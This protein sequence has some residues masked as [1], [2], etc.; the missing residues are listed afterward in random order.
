MTKF[1]QCSRG[2]RQGCPL[3]P[4]LFNTYLNDLIPQLEASN[5]SPLGL[6]NKTNV[7]C[8]MYA[9]DLILLSKSPQGLQS[10]LNKLHQ[11]CEVWHLSINTEKT[12]C[13]TLQK[14][15]K[16]NN[17]DV[18]L[19]NET[20]I[21]NVSEYTYLGITFIPSGSF[22]LTFQNLSNKANRSFF[23]INNKHPIKKL[24]IRTSLKLFDSMISP[25][26]LYCS[27][28]W[29]AFDYVDFDKWDKCEIERSHMDFCKRI[30]GLNRSTSNILTRGEMGRYPLKIAADNRFISFLRHIE[31]MPSDSLVN[32]S[33]LI[34][35]EL[36]E[37]LNCL[38]HLKNIEYS[39]SA[40]SIL[41]C[42]KS[43]TKLALRQ[44][45]TTYWKIKLHQNPKGNFLAELNKD[46][47]YETYLD[48]PVHRKLKVLTSKLR[49]SDHDL[50]IENGRRMR[51]LIPREN[52]ICHLCESN[53]LETELHFLATCSRYSTL[54]KQFMSNIFKQIP[55]VRN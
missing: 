34:N 23:S 44:A 13:M 5:S 39:T 40:P 14:K 16:T 47:C 19:I 12:K 32:Q 8:L 33:L 2:V 36:P 41:S 43:A 38:T 21:E 3:S 9:D 17:K 11:F 30:L 50:E 54:R 29:I 10:M 15:N 20:T 28:A 1:F 55:P 4:T 48:T 53:S 22:R 49:T 51:P 35:K 46:F 42:S 18:F 37:K 52:R 27:E 26:L 7:S 6:P 45:Y 25:I 31:S 24:P